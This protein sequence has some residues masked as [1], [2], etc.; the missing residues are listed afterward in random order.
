MLNS[1][2]LFLCCLADGDDWQPALKIRPLQQRKTIDTGCGNKDDCG[3]V[4][5]KT[6]R[7]ISLRCYALSIVL[8]ERDKQS[9]LISLTNTGVGRQYSITRFDGTVDTSRLVL[10]IA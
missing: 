4:M 7:Y 5:K 6:N 1:A 2:C 3:L 10:V 9:F 8:P